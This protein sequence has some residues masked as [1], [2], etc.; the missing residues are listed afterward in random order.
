MVMGTRCR[1]AVAVCFTTALAVAAGEYLSTQRKLDQIEAGKLKA[2]ARVPLTEQEITGWAA[3]EVPAGVR[4]PVV[5]FGAGTATGSA[6][7]DFGKVRRAQG[8][9]PGWLLSK[10][11]DGERPV[12]VVVRL[13]SGNGRATVDVEQVEVSGI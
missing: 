4:N 11:L 5:R 2:G 12:R 8:H 1:I 7:I 6:L 3:H 13:S 10:L 9:E